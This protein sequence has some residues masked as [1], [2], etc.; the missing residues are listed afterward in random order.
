[1][2]AGPARHSPA[3]PGTARHDPARP[4]ACLLGRPSRCT[5]TSLSSKLRISERVF[6]VTCFPASEPAFLLHE[7]GPS[8][9]GP[10]WAR[11]E[12]DNI[13]PSKV[14][15]SF[16]P[17]SLP[18]LHIQFQSECL[19]HSLADGVRPRRVARAAKPKVPVCS[20]LHSAP[21]VS[22]LCHSYPCPCPSQFAEHL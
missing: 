19:A 3:R 5:L 11:A 9:L 4:P 12:D 18:I 6:F 13:W 8:A 22:E 17:G 14:M 20:S 1:M 21:T 15:V 2:P 10:R 16:L 7:Q